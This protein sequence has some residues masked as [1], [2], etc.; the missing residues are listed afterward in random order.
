MIR[1]CYPSGTGFILEKNKKREAGVLDLMQQTRYILYAIELRLIRPAGKTGKGRVDAS[2]TR[3]NGL[4]H[5]NDNTD[6]AGQALEQHEGKH[7]DAWKKSVV[8]GIFLLIVLL[9][10]AAIFMLKNA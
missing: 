7:P 2:G 1:D 3:R 4:N 6:H 10:L 9:L 5:N 8:G